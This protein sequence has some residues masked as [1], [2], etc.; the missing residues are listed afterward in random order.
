MEDIRDQ[1]RRILEITKR[2]GLDLSADDRMM[3]RRGTK[4]WKV[5][6]PGSPLQK[7][8]RFMVL[9]GSLCNTP[10]STLPDWKEYSSDLCTFTRLNA[11]GKLQTQS[12][13]TV[14]DAGLLTTGLPD[15]PSTHS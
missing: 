6:K 15:G 8:K 2:E 14:E 5:M 12:G 7:W 13:M 9:H 1:Y 3:A 10:L 11:E 4:M